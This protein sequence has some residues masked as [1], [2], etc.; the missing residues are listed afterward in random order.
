MTVKFILHVNKPDNLILFARAAKICVN[1]D[2][3][4]GEWTVLQYDS[5]PPVTISCIKRKSC[6]TLFENE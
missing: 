6:V 3:K 4:E 1:K 5:I 2:M